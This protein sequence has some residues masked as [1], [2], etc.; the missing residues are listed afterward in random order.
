MARAI[1]ITTEGVIA[2]TDINFENLGRLFG[3]NSYFEIV[4]AKS[5]GE[6]FTDIDGTAVMVVDEEGRVKDLP[7]NKKATILY[8]PA[9]YRDRYF[10]A[11]DAYLFGEGFTVNGSNFLDLP[12]RIGLADVE[13]LIERQTN[14]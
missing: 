4:H 11:G 13:D 10:I 8:A 14:R 1:K 9:A 7:Y 2:E 3:E 12:S 5:L 6:T